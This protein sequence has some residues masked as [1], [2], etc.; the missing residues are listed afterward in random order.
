M[1]AV[2]LVSASVS[3]QTR[4]EPHENSFSPSQ[5]VQLGRQAASDVRR[6][7]PMLK[8]RPTDALVEQM[9]KAAAA[10]SGG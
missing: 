6:H 7:L 9:V 10:K 3:A 1:L 8:D 5:D 2:L 4:I